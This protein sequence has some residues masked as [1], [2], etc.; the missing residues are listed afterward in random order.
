M[1][2]S[3]INLYLR[4]KDL[5]AF[6]ASRGVRFGQ[7]CKV[8]SSLATSFGTEPYLITIGNHVEISAN[9]TF[10]THDGALWVLRESNPEADV[11]GRIVV[12]DNVFIGRG[13]TLLP[14]TSIGD[15]SVVGAGAVVKG[16]LEA[17][18][19]Y[20]GVPARKIS[21]FEEF[22]KRALLGVLA[23]KQ[24]SPD[25]KRRFLMNHFNLD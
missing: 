4:K 3:L 21:S 18:G 1:I 12:G 25:E 17:N 15:N 8:I 5:Q 7:G 24:M 9:V 14:G 11:F 10:I 6:A 16:H 20:A 13:A 19:V 2:K 23:T 22:Q